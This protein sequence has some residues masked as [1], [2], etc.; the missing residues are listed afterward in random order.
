MCP[1]SQA[2]VDDQLTMNS[3]KSTDKYLVGT[4][5]GTHI[6]GVHTM[7]DNDTTYVCLSFGFLCQSDAQLFFWNIEIIFSLKLTVCH[8]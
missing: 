2:T 6:K 8:R 5:L 1:S 4:Y 7:A 3:P